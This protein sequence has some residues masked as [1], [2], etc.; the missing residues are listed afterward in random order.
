MLKRR[1]LSSRSVGLTAPPL[2]SV[3]LKVTT[4]LL[5]APITT[6]EISILRPGPGEMGADLPEA[7]GAPAG[8]G[9]PA[10]PGAAVQPRASAAT[11]ATAA[12]T[13]MTRGK[14]FIENSFFGYET[15]F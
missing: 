4:G 5:S 11:S 14:R 15:N 12:N 8:P 10:G 1:L 9:G 2:S 6:L 3:I 7:P 13:R